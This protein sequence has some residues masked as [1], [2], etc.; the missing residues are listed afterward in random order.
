MASLQPL[1]AS[2]LDSLPPSPIEKE[3]LDELVAR[4]IYESRDKSSP[5]NRKVQWEYLLKNDIFLLAVRFAVVK[6]LDT[7]NFNKQEL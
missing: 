1:L 2:L 7:L 3:K 6:K 4:T 5:E